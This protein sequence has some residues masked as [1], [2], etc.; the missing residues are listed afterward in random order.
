MKSSHAQFVFIGLLWWSTGLLAQVRFL[1][2]STYFSVNCRLKKEFKQAVRRQVWPM[3]IIVH[4]WWN[5]DQAELW[6]LPYF[7][8]WNKCFLTFLL[9]VRLFFAICHER[10][11]FRQSALPPPPPP[12]VFGNW[13]AAPAIR[14][15]FLIDIF[16]PTTFAVLTPR[17][18]TLETFTFLP[19]QLKLFGLFPRNIKQTID[20]W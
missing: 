19:K 8:L 2:K 4:F 3:K 17:S 12:F 10:V 11:R 7:S 9:Q 1:I 16:R 5:P 6:Y 13:Q 18:S 14:N 15:F 20:V